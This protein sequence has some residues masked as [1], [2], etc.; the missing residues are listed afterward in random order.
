MGSTFQGEILLKEAQSTSI[1]EEC[2]GIFFLKRGSIHPCASYKQFSGNCTLFKEMPLPQMI[3]AMLHIFLITRSRK[4]F[5][6]MQLNSFNFD[7]LLQHSYCPF[8]FL[9]QRKDEEWENFQH[10]S[11]P[12][13]LFYIG[14]LGSFSFLNKCNHRSLLRHPSDSC[15]GLCIPL[16]RLINSSRRFHQSWKKDKFSRYT[17]YLQSCHGGRHPSKHLQ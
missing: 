15:I 4:T 10:H 8:L 1:V 7:L 16:N 2:I 9:L 13:N 17:W 12:M 6:I 11:C 5:Y 14:A 3:W